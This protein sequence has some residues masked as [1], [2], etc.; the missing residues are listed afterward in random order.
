MDPDTART[1]SGWPAR[2]YLY[3]LSANSRHSLEEQQVG[4]DNRNGWKER[5]RER[6][7][8]R[9][10]EWRQSVLSVQ[11]D[12]DSYH[13][14]VQGRVLLLS[15]DC[16]T[17]PLIRILYCWVLS[18]VV[19]SNILKVFGMTRTG[20]ETRS[21]GSLAN[22]IPTNTLNVPLPYKCP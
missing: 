20:I 15:Q 3:Q 8:E 17:L 6:E 12:D 7:R 2:T 21:P 11:L 19:S 9:V 22:T 4:M 1:T 13:T 10:R 14:E 5:E 16:S 18:K